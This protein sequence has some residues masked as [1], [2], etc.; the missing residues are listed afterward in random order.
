MA[1]RKGLEQGHPSQI[2]SSYGP[3]SFGWG[4][5]ANK[6]TDGRSGLQE[7][8]DQVH[9]SLS[10]WCMMRQARGRMGPWDEGRAYESVWSS[11]G[12]GESPWTPRSCPPQVC[13]CL[14][15]VMG[16]SLPL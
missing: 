1:G 3:L 9:P 12:L 11:P 16:S 14:P 4:S 10:S 15:L 13:A 8:S 6:S 2:M 5:V 7:V